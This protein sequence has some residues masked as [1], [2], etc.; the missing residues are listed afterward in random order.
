MRILTS[1]IVAGALAIGPPAAATPAAAP[2]RK[3]VFDRD[4]TSI[5]F[6]VRHL[7]TRVHGQFSTFEGSIDFDE[8]KFEN[9]RVR[10]SIQTASIDTDVAKRDEDLRSPRFFD[11]ARF[12][13]IDFTSDKVSKAEGSKF[14]VEGNLT[15]H[16]VT[17]RVVLDAQFLGSATDPW[18][19]PKYA[20]SATTRLNRKDFGMQ[21][22]EAI[23]T[24]GVL[25]GDEVDITLEIEANPA[26]V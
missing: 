24:G 13:A 21:W 25:V 5:A 23:E 19:N 15:M 2:V 22:N 12:P 4:H 6:S 26:P 9:S 7:L 8:A 20:F 1:A 3:L 17:K 14:R 16:G 11:A 10:V 18:G